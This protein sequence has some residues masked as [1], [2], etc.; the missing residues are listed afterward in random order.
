MM[1]IEVRTWIQTVAEVVLAGVTTWTLVVLRR[2]A[3]DT[4]KIAENSSEQ[5]ENSQTPFVAL[6]IRTD[7]HSN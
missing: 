6:V 5:L 2:Y 4:K 1:M 3:R 7:Q